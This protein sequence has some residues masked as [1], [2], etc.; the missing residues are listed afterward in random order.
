MRIT[1]FG[2]TGKI[3]RLVVDRLLDDGHDVTTFVRNP[4]KLENPRA[5]PT[6][7]AGRWGW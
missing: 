3:G 5:R 4:A 7:L 1:V 2:A 6:V